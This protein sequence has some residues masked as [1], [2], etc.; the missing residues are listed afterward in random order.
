MIFAIISTWKV[1]GVLKDVLKIARKSKGYTQEDV[2]NHLCVKRQT[3]SAY[4]RGVSVPDAITLQKLADFFKV[5]CDYLL[6]KSDTPNF[7]TPVTPTEPL[8]VEEAIEETLEGFGVKDEIMI[9]LLKT[10]I[11]QQAKIDHNESLSKEFDASGYNVKL[12]G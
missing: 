5:T 7:Q 10:V 6:G 3:Y 1:I 2:A 8:S 12:G 4:E 11:I 9:N